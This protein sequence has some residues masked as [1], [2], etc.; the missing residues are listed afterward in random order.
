MVEEMKVRNAPDVRVIDS[1]RI[2]SGSPQIAWEYKSMTTDR[3]SQSPWILGD[4]GWELVSVI[5]EVG[6]RA[7]YYFKRRKHGVHRD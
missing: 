2:D 6:S 1:A 3:E 5:P 7:T 4:H